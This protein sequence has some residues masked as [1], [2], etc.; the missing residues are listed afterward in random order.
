MTSSTVKTPL[1]AK[2]RSGFLIALLCLTVLVAMVFRGSFQKDQVLH[3]NDGPLGIVY[4]HADQPFAAFT[5]YWED[6]NWV[7]SEQ[8][9]ALPNLTQ[10]IYL[11]LGPLFQGREGAVT[12]AK[13]YAPVAL[14]VLGLCVWFFLRQLRFQPAVCVLGGAAAVLNMNAFSNACWGLPSW[15]LAWGCVFLALAALVSSSIRQ[16]WIKLALAGFAVGAN[17]M[18]GYDMG[19]IFSLYVAAFAFWLFVI[20]AP[21]SSVQTWVKAAGKVIV[22]AAFALFISAQ[23][24][25]TLINTQ[26]KGVV[27]AQTVEKNSPENW[28]RAT[29]WSLPK[30]EALRVIIPGLYGYRMDTPGGGQYWGGVGSLDEFPAARYSGS[31]EYAGILVVL[32]AVWAIAQAFRARQSPY[33][34]REK[35]IIWFWAGAAVI[36]LVFAFGRHAPFYQLIYPLPFFSTIRNPIKFMQPFH[37]AV[38]ILF[39]YGLEDLCRRCLAA[40]VNQKP[41]PVSD[42][43]KAWWK[44]ATP[45]ETKWVFGTVAVL[46]VSMLSLMLYAASSNELINQLKAVGFAPDPSQNISPDLAPSIAKF[47][48]GEVCWYV[49]FL[50][51]SITAVTL[52]IS[53]VM[54]GSRAKIAILLLGFILISD[55]VRANS[56]WIIYWNYKEKYATNPVVDFLREK[57]YEHRV[58][59]LPFRVNEQLGLLQQFYHGQWLQHQFPYYNIQSLDIPQEPRVLIENKTYRGVFSGGN[60]GLLVREWELTNTRYLLGLSG[61]FLQALNQQ[62]DGGRSRFQLQMPFGLSR[63]SANG[64]VITDADPNGPFAL[65]EFT[66]ALPRAKLFTQWKANQDDTNTLAQLS[67]LAFNPHETVLV[68]DELPP[69]AVPL[70]LNATNSGTVAIDRYSPKVVHLTANATAPSVLL[71]NDKFNPG[72]K[73][74]VNGQPAKLLRCN[75]LM[76]G[77]YLQSGNSTVEFR[78]EPPVTSLYVSLAAILFGLGLCGV[79]V[80]QSKQSPTV[81]VAAPVSPAKK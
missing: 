9:S 24:L 11:L 58:A 42:R 52:I 34:A 65:I 79:V 39:A 6:L 35:K 16:T 53:G 30:I 48:Q 68:S 55:G 38:L 51:L 19:A 64:P 66:G 3:S 20:E 72:W 70:V 36:S 54:A 1:P 10:A 37:V 49:L 40:P 76:R 80:Y 69:A 81:P 22:L 26:I 59:I 77:V 17:V 41:A 46:G 32:I 5:G 18:Q 27:E 15:T 56:P 28:I 47:S 44:A 21:E 8:P 71:L 61:G 60:P 13:F 74:F 14:L 25:S 63:P 2:P 31:G 62:V 57:P 43:F 29:Q 50:G 7:G 78:F 23:V 73:V 33:S 45:F 67:N 12:F 4:A 75:Y